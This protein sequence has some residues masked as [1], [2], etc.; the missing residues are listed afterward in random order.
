MSTSSIARQSKS[1]NFG[2][3]VVAF[4]GIGVAGCLSTPDTTRL[5]CNT[6]AG[7]PKDYFC[8]SCMPARH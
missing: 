6:Q 5:K 7:C 8:V 2:L 4:A 3:W 1:S